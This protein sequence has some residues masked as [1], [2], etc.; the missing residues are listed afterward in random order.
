MVASFEQEEAKVV[1]KAV[2]DMIQEK[3]ERPIKIRGQ[4]QPPEGVGQH[5]V[6]NNVELTVDCQG[7]TL[8][9][10]F[11]WSVQPEAQ[12]VQVL[13]EKPQALVD[14]FQTLVGLTQKDMS[15]FDANYKGKGVDEDERWDMRTMPM[16]L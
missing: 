7:Q 10:L 16:Y 4:F 15:I 2:V 1:L 5:E 6:W 11:L 12:N 13:T 14:A 9:T 3:D 8:A